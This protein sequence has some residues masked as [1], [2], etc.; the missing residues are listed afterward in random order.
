M[1]DMTSM[2]PPLDWQSFLHTWE[3]RPFWSGFALLAFG[4]YGAG[5][6]VCRR[7]QVRGVH[8]ANAVAFVAGLVLLVFTV[9]SAI[10]A[11]AMAIFWDHMIEHLMLI[12]VVPALLVL[13][14]PLTLLRAAAETRGHGQAV[15]AFLRST[16]ISVV[17]HPLVGLAAYSIVIVGTHLT[18][19]MDVMATHAWVMHAEQVL[20]LVSG[21]LFLLTLIGGEPIRWKLPHLARLALVLVAMTPDTLVGIVLMQTN[22]DMFPVMEGIRPMW[23]PPPLQDLS[24]AGGLMWAG[25]DG[26]M[27]LI[28]FGVVLALIIDRSQDAVLGKGLESV[29]RATLTSQLSRRD[30]EAVSSDEEVDVDADEAMLDAYNRMLGRLSESGDTRPS[31]S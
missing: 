7:H 25:G 10:D 20:Y 8:P 23:A 11:Y 3:L 1:H 5:L 22:H 9:S 29:R 30:S 2:L 12:M 16:P 28:G 27:M 19:F 4:A 13:G 21:Y 6:V 18:S 14:R 31:S 15:D 24:T 26:L 17:T